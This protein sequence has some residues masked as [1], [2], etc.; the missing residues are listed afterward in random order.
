[1]KLINKNFGIGVLVLCFALS[2]VNVSLAA[3]DIEVPPV[4]V[5]PYEAATLSLQMID[6][7]LDNHD[8]AEVLKG[9]VDENQTFAH[10]A[11]AHHQN[12]ALENINETM[13]NSQGVSK[14]DELINLTED[15]EKMKN[16]GQTL[17]PKT[18]LIEGN[19]KILAELKNEM[20]ALNKKLP[21]SSMNSLALPPIIVNASNNQQP[22]A[23]EANAKDETIKQQALELKTKQEQLDLLKSELENKIT[24]E[25]NQSVLAVKV[26]EEL[27]QI[28][29]SRNYQALGEKQTADLNAR[30]QEKEA[31][32]VKIKKDLYDLQ[33]SSSAKDTE[34]Q[35]KD[36]SLSI[37]E[38]KIAGFKNELAL[39]RQQPKDIPN[40]DE[41]E[42]EEKLK[43]A[44]D[45][46][47]GQGRLIKILAQKLDDCGQSV[48]LTK[49]VGK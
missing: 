1:M 42:K 15:V 18:D 20:M 24:E 13:A 47:D 19:Y 31:Q 22:A 6:L 10:S 14:Y 36:L 8:I 43:Q 21:S 5:Q 16:A 27:R 2:S 30:L 48:N 4:I 11:L 38:Q 44:L 23:P 17:S 40:S 39:A 7:Y 33:E 35:A 29:S 46:I 37:M 3:P 41:D 32:I 12:V 28:L 34:S 26:R 9:L 25:K 45:K 49:D